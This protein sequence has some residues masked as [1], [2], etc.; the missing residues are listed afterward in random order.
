M[1]EQL[2]SHTCELLVCLGA[3]DFEE[4]D[5]EGMSALHRHASRGW[6]HSCLTLIVCGASI[7]QRT[8]NEETSLHIA[9][10]QRN[11]ELALLL[12]SFGADASA[13]NKLDQTPFA[14]AD[15]KFST[16]LSKFSGKSS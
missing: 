4:L 11:K 2:S 6:V 7:D 16:E 14:L 3:N 1:I 9:F 12:L 15:S 5:S 8:P 10:R 13:T